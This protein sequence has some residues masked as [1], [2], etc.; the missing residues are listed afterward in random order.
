MVE[1]GLHCGTRKGMEP[2]MDQHRLASPLAWPNLAKCI[3]PAGN[4]QGDSLRA[5]AVSSM[6]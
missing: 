2:K 4:T 1:C 6:S 3:A 5:T